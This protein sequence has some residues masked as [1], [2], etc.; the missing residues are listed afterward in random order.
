V[1]RNE[2]LAHLRPYIDRARSFS[3]W[4]HDIQVRPP[5]VP[6]SYSTIVAEA[7]QRVTSALDLGTGGG[8]RLA[9]MRA[10]LPQRTVATEEWHVNAPVAQQRLAPLGIPLVRASSLDLPFR[11]ATFDLILSRHEDFS[12]S[13][14]AR[15]LAPGGAFITQQVGHDDWREVRSFFPEAV[16]SGDH[17]IRYQRE[18]AAVG[19]RVER[20]ERHEYT[21][22]YE[23]LGDFVFMLLTAPWLLPDLDVERDIDRLLALYD[24]QRTPDDAIAITE[25]REI[26]VAAKPPP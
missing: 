2:A 8:E 12:P 9:A 23:T 15:V 7:A 25:T 1:N 22:V 11:N 26:I 14:V 13:D 10:S 16:D 20:A 24:A 3:G 6:W 17:F 21:A 18:F 5:P 19:M 4:L